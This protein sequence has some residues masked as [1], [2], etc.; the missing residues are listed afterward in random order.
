MFLNED[1]L[2]IWEE[3]SELNEAKADTQKLVDFAGQDI[4][5]R[6]LAIKNKL[7]A[8]ENDLYYWIKNKTPEELEQAINKTE[9]T[10][11][12]TQAKKEIADKG[13]ELVCSS[14]HWN[15]Y[16]ITTFEASQKYGRDTKWCITGI[17]N[18]GDKYW[19]EY[20]ENGIDFYFLINKEEYD[21]RGKY[22]KV[23]IALHKNKRDCEVFNQQDTPI[24]LSK[25]PYLEEITIPGLDIKSLEDCVYCFECG[26]P[27]NPEDICFGPHDECYCHDCFDNNYFKCKG[28]G[29]LHF[30]YI[31]FFEDEHGNKF[32]SDC[33]DED[34]TQFYSKIDNLENFSYKIICDEDPYRYF[35]GVT[36][37]KESLHLRVL[38][39]VSNI[40]IIATKK[41]K[42][43]I[44]SAATGEVI[45]ETLGVSNNTTKEVMSAVEDYLNSYN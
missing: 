17:N 22:S 42:I 28:C 23:A 12:N 25:I 35:A 8:P 11:S 33:E 40:P 6:F 32:C 45:Y 39:A 30:A 41:T 7:K 31:T 29:E 26:E 5:D 4:A 37:S 10:K 44:I 1:F 20:K 43:D 38:N 27:V 2:Q 16:H 34:V 3:L 24:T 18:W 36:N 13:A 9:N 21:A 19:N 14:E 15:V